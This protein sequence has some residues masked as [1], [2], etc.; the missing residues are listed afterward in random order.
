MLQISLL[1]YISTQLQIK[2]PYHISNGNLGLNLV[3]SNDEIFTKDEMFRK[4]AQ[5]L[6]DTIVNDVLNDISEYDSKLSSND[7]VE[8][9]FL[10]NHCLVCGYN[11]FKI[12][13]N[14][15]YRNSVIKK[16]IELSQNYLEHIKRTFRN[17]EKEK[18]NFFTNYIARIKTLI[19]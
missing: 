15:K 6:L 18:I 7:L 9:E 14:T 17:L 19:E 12:F 4:E 8:Y 16:M 10:I 1:K 13:E 11:F 2:L 5:D 3:D